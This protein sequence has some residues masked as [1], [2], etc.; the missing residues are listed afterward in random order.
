MIAQ[1]KARAGLVIATRDWHP[2]K[3]V[4][5]DSWPVH[6]VA[7][8]PGAEYGEI[9]RD[10]IDIEIYKGF[11]NAND[12]FSGFEGFTA[13]VGDAKN[14]FKKAP[15]AKSLEEIVSETGI[16]VV[17]IVGLATDYCVKATAIDATNLVKNGVLKQVI[18]DLQGIAAVNL[19][20]DDG[21]KALAA[22]REQG[23]EIPSYKEPFVENPSAAYPFFG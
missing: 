21:E 13:L 20:S 22:M 23:V 10:A 2:E 3:T 11:E 8:S 19:K 9:D 15:G 18:V 6:C 14:G 1:T 5:F 4:H 7:G 17:R 12:G 16:R